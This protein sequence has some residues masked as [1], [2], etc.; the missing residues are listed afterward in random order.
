[1]PAGRLHIPLNNPTGQT[2]FDDSTQHYAK[3]LVTAFR[4]IRE[5]NKMEQ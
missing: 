5:W 4:R 2:P 3:Q 1:M